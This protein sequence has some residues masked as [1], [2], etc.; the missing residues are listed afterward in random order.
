MGW[1]LG[2][3]QKVE[4][5]RRPPAGKHVSFV[6]ESDTQAVIFRRDRFFS[7]PPCLKAGAVHD[8]LTKGAG[9]EIA[10]KLAAPLQSSYDKPANTT[11]KPRPPPN[12]NFPLGGM[13]AS[14]TSAVTSDTSGRKH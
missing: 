8:S 5:N 3:K 10:G 11:H 12:Y 13:G 4:T 1:K 6:P 2:K 14:P 9:P 7:A